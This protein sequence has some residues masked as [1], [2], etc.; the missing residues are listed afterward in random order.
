MFRIKKLLCLLLAV[1]M[2][3]SL[4]PAAAFADGAGGCTKAED[5]TAETHEEGCPKFVP[6]KS[7]CS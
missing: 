5:C 4:L 6:A 3:C 2:I 7:S 1:M